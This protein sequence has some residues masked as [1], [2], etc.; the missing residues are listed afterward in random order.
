MS[1]VV[2]S[3][4]RAS[5]WVQAGGSGWPLSAGRPAW[6]LRHGLGQKVVAQH[7]CAIQN[8]TLVLL[9]ILP[10]WQFDR[11]P[12]HIIIPASCA[13]RFSLLGARPL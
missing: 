6:R 4:G 12:L 1:S 13:E 5:D 8:T 9:P 10:F 11:S 7:R 3:R 2:A